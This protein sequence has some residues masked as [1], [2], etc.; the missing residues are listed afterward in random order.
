MEQIEEKQTCDVVPSGGPGSLAER[1]G[2][3]NLCEID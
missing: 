2:W 3:W 1:P